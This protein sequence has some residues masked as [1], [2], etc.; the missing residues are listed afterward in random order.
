MFSL[1]ESH[2]TSSALPLKQRERQQKETHDKQQVSRILFDFI[3]SACSLTVLFSYH[4]LE[5]RLFLPTGPVYGHVSLPKAKNLNILLVVQ[6]DAHWTTDWSAQQENYICC[7][8]LVVDVVALNIEQSR[9]DRWLGSR[10]IF[11]QDFVFEFSSMA[12][13]TFLITLVDRLR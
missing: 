12:L 10:V 3:L 11:G 8:N 7:S 13:I 1:R 6:G 2:P 5:T 4:L 9:I